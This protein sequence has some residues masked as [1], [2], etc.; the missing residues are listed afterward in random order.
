MGGSE[1]RK[2]FWGGSDAWGSLQ[3]CSD[4]KTRPP[5]LSDKAMEPS[6]KF[7][8][9]KF[10][11]LDVRSSTVRDWGVPSVPTPSLSLPP[12]LCQSYLGVPSAPHPVSPH[13][14]RP[15]HPHPMLP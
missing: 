10:P 6:I 11:H 3:T 1:A 8:N 5:F 2:W 13:P 14:Q 15:H 7:I 4:P 12:I 9:K